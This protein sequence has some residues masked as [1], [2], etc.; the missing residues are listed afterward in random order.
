MKQNTVTIGVIGLGG[1]GRSLLGVLL[2]MADVN[3]AAICDI[4]ADKLALGIDKTKEKGCT[5]IA[6]YLDY[7]ELLKRDDIQ[8][9]IIP[10]NWQTHIEIA[11][12]VMKAGKYAGPE[13][14]GASSIDELYTLVKT[15]EE[16]GMPCMMLENCNYGRDEMML[17]NMVRMGV[18]GEVV[19]AQAGYEHDLRSSIT[20]GKFERGH[21]RTDHNFNRNGDLYPTHG[22]GP[23]AKILNINRGNRFVSLTSTASKARGAAHYINEKGGDDHPLKGLE[24]QK[25]DVITTVIKCAGGE[26]I[27]ITHD[28]TLPRP[29]SRAGRLQGTKAIWMEDNASLYLDNISPAHEWESVDKYREQFEHPLWQ[30]YINSK[31]QDD[32]DGMDYLV[33][34]AFA[35]SIR[36]QSR[37]PI[38]VYDTAAWM[39]ITCLS[40]QSIAMGSAPVAV[41]DFT[42]GKWVDRE[43]APTGKYAL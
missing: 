17:L 35:E 5:D 1:R 8:G 31:V 14:A 3:V 36:N 33:L 12:D 21:Y 23:M 27:L 10:T 6:G 25:G 26:S 39:A 19:H 11:I 38:D 29:Y 4:Q 40:E 15:S 16:T 42:N 37:T 41:P 7:K 18:F 34:S 20:M 24:W 28:T 2:D 22:L 13:V 32:H 30:D 9:V 43:E